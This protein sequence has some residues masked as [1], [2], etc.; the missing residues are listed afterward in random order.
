MKKL[1]FWGLMNPYK[2]QFIIA[3]AQIILVMIASYIG[4]W[5]FARDILWSNTVFYAGLT[6]FFIGLA[7]YPIRRARY[8]FWKKTFVKQKTMDAILLISYMLTAVTVSNRD[9]N[10]AWKAAMNSTQNVQI[11]FKESTSNS[12]QLPAKQLTFK[13]KL[14]KKYTKFV[15]KQ[16]LSNGNSG[17][18][19]GVTGIIFLMILLM[20]VVLGLSCGLMCSG[21]STTGLILLIGGWTLILTLGIQG[22]RNL[23]GARKNNYQP[24]PQ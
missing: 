1:A 23:A 14:I 15:I 8:A 11:V 10:I 13:E 17:A 3:I 6:L 9:A 22:I 16:K 7:G 24:M 21:S 18:V 19:M 12:V 20:L 5:L 4:I 2:T